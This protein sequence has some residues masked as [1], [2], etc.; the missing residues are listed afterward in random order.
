MPV[1]GVP[2]T[3]ERAWLPAP[4]SHRLSWLFTTGKIFLSAVVLLVAVVWALRLP[5]FSD[6]LVQPVTGD[7]SATALGHPAE[8][9]SL[10]CTSVS[11]YT[12]LFVAAS[13]MVLVNIKHG[14]AWFLAHVV[15][16]STTKQAS[17]SSP[18]LATEEAP[19]KQGSKRAADTSVAD[20][21]LLDT[22]NLTEPQ[23]LNL[24]KRRE[25]HRQHATFEPSEG[26]E[27]GKKNLAWLDAL[28]VKQKTSTCGGLNCESEQ[29]E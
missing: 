20:P 9:P 11:G 5:Y 15:P 23:R 18:T 10:P 27:K 2:V 28:K 12:E 8:T 25:W 21:D 16:G 13:S 7:N 26:G 6:Y 3:S 19:L 29:Q 24:K 4:A 17:N 22:P 14:A 1:P